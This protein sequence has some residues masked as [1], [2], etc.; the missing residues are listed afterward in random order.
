MLSH[1]RRASPRCKLI[2][3]ALPWLGGRAVPRR[4]LSSLDSPSRGA[5]GPGRHRHE[6][7]GAEP[8][9][10]HRPSLLDIHRTDA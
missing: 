7:R 5:A 9:V 4:D 10:F 3:G 1:T 8:H 6:F 2:A